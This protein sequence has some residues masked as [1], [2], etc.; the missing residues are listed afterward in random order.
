MTV[1]IA[2]VEDAAETIAA[3]VIRTPTNAAPGLSRLTGADI[4]LK[5]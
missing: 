1:T 4:H 5:L 2:D 3:D